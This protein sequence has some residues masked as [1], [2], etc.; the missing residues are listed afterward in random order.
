MKKII[1]VLLISFVSTAD[2]ATYY[3]S[4]STGKDTNT[5]LSHA[6]AWKT[7]AK[8]NGVTFATGDDVYFLAGDTWSGTQLQID[9]AGTSNNRAILGSYYMSGSETVGVPDG[10]NKPTIYGGFV[11][12]SGDIGNVPSGPYG[13]LVVILGAYVTLENLRVENSSG[14]GIANQEGFENNIIQDNEVIHSV[15]SSIATWNYSHYIIVRNNYLYQSL[16]ARA[17]GINDQAYGGSTHPPCLRI[18][19]SD[20]ALVENN[21]LVEGK[22]EGIDLVKN[23]DYGIVRANKI[24]NTSAVGLYI[25]KGSN[26]VLEHNLIV[27]DASKSY[28]GIASVLEGPNYGPNHDNIIRNNVVI[29]AQHCIT[30]DVWPTAVAAG[31]TISGQIIGNICINTD[32]GIRIQETAASYANGLEIA[33]NIIWGPPDVGTVCYSPT[34]ANIDFHNNSWGF[35]PSDSDCD[36]SGDV[37]GDPTFTYT[38]DWAAFDS[39]N[40]P[41]TTDLLRNQVVILRMQGP[42]LIL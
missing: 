29:N 31:M 8:V 22:C 42:T 9:W 4:Q 30:T 12:N 1:W 27:H 18:R 3:V 21:T 40:P 7:I 32:T 5:G 16:W 36:G 17:E 25:D 13:A 28:G 15:G 35:N 38:G 2:A 33:N 14:F 39:S 34:T 23:S 26:N 10:V 24:Y 6:Q 19:N 11:P 37:Y 41:T 20:Y